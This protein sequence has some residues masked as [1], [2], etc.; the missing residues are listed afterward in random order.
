MFFIFSISNHR[1]VLGNAQ[2]VLC[3]VCGQF[4]S[5]EISMTYQEFTLFFIPIF[6]YQHRFYASMGCCG[7]V[8]TLSEDVGKKFRRH[9]LVSIDEDDLTLVKRGKGITVCRNCHTNVED[10]FVF[11]PKCGTHLHD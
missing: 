2:T 4:A 11:C 8:Y 6:R 7:S 10:H 1:K 5:Y 3:D 9:E